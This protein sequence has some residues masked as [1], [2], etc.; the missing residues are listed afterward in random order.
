MSTKFEEHSKQ[1]IS[2]ILEYQLR[3]C[4][5]FM[6]LSL[7]FMGPFRVEGLGNQHVCIKAYGLVLCQI[8]CAV[9]VL[10]VPEYDMASFLI[11]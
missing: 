1:L 4:P 7:D 10:A 3:P 9:K 11:A 2:Q 5:P 6:N 8:T